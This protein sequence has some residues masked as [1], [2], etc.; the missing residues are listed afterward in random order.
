MGPGLWAPTGS[1]HPIKCPTS[2]FICPGAFDEEAHEAAGIHPAG[3][4]PIPL[5]TGAIETTVEVRRKL[6]TVTTELTLEQDVDTPL[7]ET[8]L[9][10]SLAQILG[11]SLDLVVVEQ[12]NAGSLVVR[13]S[14]VASDE[15]ERGLLAARVQALS[16]AEL[17]LALGMGSNLSSAVWFGERIVILNETRST[18][19]PAG[20]W[21]T[22]GEVISCAPSTYNDRV[23]QDKA[24]ACRPCPSH[25]TSARAA[26]NISQC[27]CET[28]YY[29]ARDDPTDAG[30]PRCLVC[31]VGL[32][33][34]VDGLSLR[35]LPLQRGFYRPSAESRDVRR[36]PDADAGCS[37]SSDADCP[38]GTASTG[39]QGGTLAPYCREG[40][41]GT[42]CQLC[43]NLTSHYV[44]AT[45]DEAAH[46]EACE[47]VVREFTLL[48]GV[49]ISVTLIAA[50]ALLAVRHASHRCRSVTNMVAAFASR[51]LKVRNKLKIVIGFYQVSGSQGPQRPVPRRAT[52]E[53][54]LKTDHTCLASAALAQIVTQVETTYDFNLPPEVRQFLAYF[55]IGISIGVDAVP[56]QCL[57]VGGYG[58]R[59]TFWMIAPAVAVALV[60]F[61]SLVSSRG[62][63]GR[64]QRSKHGTKP[65]RDH[66]R[67]RGRIHGVEEAST[68]LLHTV[69]PVVLEVAFLC[70]PYVSIVAL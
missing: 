45:S 2:G 51:K 61:A 21:C 39:C 10:S 67:R 55:K 35:N 25:A 64:G 65:E 50:L 41:R 16:S 26:T 14:V 17:S 58:A 40:L 47:V 29:D 57:G 56:L 8:A 49:V 53:L 34:S 9:A 1:A 43:A 48:V 70:Y 62:G 66:A 23:S 22:A 24:T 20:S 37:M 46:C 5:S 12:V 52:S 54:R 6:L 33:C 69:L 31:F 3:A 27:Y 13:V 44:A 59:L 15:A 68:K 60:A 19:C 4:L 63:D 7:E 18:H 11:V 32:N 36:C 42:F 28:G 38:A 30:G